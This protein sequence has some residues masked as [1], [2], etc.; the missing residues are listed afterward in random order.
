MK[1]M[2]IYGPFK[3]KI[4]HQQKDQQFRVIISFEN[5]S[6]REEFIKKNK[7]LK[8][9]GKFDFIPSICLTLEKEKVFHYEEEELIG[10]IEEDQKLYLSMLDVLD[11]LDLDVYKNSHIVYE[12]KNINIGIID[13]GINRNIPSISNV[14]DSLEI[15][16]KSNEIKA[17][18]KEIT[19]GTIMASIIGNQFKNSEDNFI[20]I[21]PKANLIDLKLESSNSEYYISDVLKI[22]DKINNGKIKIDIL[23]ISLT[24]QEPSDGKDILSIA[25]NLY[26][27]NGPIIVSPA[28]NNGPDPYSIGS[29]GAADRVM[30][31]GALTKE[32]TIPNFSGRGPTL[33]D[34]IKPDICLPGSN[35]IVPLSNDLQIKVTGTSVSA[36]IG[37]GIIALIKE[38]NPQISYEAI[39]DLINKSVFNLKLDPNSQ[40][41]G[42]IRVSDLFNEL[43]LFHEVLVPYNYLIMRSLKLAIEFFAIFLGVFYLF[44]FFKLIVL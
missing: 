31:I 42:I 39:M 4:E 44:Y 17:S 43:D 13:D 20:G 23:L 40:G 30:T 12:G 34:R 7:D 15:Y 22:F 21:A 35:I 14:K 38:S 2:T 11:I 16:K 37:V 10:Q 41:L 1:K 25:C 28:G 33:D 9:L 6:N 18:E 29:P 19:H 8:I 36:S 3:K 26:S 24:A 32:Y 5:L 27:E